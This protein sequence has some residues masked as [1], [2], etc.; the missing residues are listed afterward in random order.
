[1]LHG[2]THV[3]SQKRKINKNNKENLHLFCYNDD[4]LS[5]ADRFHSFFSLGTLRTHINKKH[6]PITASREPVNCPYPACTPTLRHGEHLK[7][8]L[9]VV[10]NLKL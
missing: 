5:P 1:M 2:S 9:A 8:H 3:A 4:N 7:N 10:H 6:S